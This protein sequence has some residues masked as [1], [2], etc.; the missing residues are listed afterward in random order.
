[1]QKLYKWAESSTDHSS[2]PTKSAYTTLSEARSYLNLALAR[3]LLDI[4]DPTVGLNG[5][6][7]GPA[8]PS[9]RERV[10][11]D[12][13]AT[14]SYQNV[15]F[16]LLRFAGYLGTLPL[17]ACQPLI[18]SRLIIVSHNFKRRRF[19]ELHLPAVKFPVASTEYVGID[20]AF[21]ED[22]DKGEQRRMEIKEGDLKRGFGSWKEDLYGTGEVLS[23]KRKYRGWSEARMKEVVE[24]CASGGKAD[25]ER[26]I[27]QSLLT[28]RGGASRMEIFPERVPWV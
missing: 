9:M 8:T 25:E 17:Q 10:F 23:T 18:P 15:L 21:E 27:T 3:G 24:Q 22:E 7:V 14:D 1:M 2:G 26:K 4:T 13:Y 28:W 6:G 20:P 12:T 11:L 16:P 5:E 19:M